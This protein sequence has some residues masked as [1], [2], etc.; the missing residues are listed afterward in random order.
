VYKELLEVYRS[1]W[2][3]RLLLLDDQSEEI[4]L[5]EAIKRELLDELSHP[6]IRTSISKKYELAIKRII[7]AS[8]ITDSNKLLLMKAY[9]DELEKLNTKR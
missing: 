6:R 5:K 9:T 3:H 2:N 8:L 1:Q 4:V 7:H